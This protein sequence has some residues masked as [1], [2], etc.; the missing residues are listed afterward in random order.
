MVEPSSSPARA[1]L[2]AAGAEVFAD[3]GFG[4][5]STREICELAG[6]SVNMIHHY[7]GSKAGLLTAIIDQYGSEVLALPARLLASPPTSRDDLLSRMTLL[8]ETTLEACL[9]HRTLLK[10]VVREDASPDALRDYASAFTSFLEEG[11]RAGVV[12]QGLDA[13]MVTGA[14]LDRILNQVL[15]IPGIKSAHGTDISDP[16]YRQAWCAANVDFFLHGM[17]PSR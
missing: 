9:A 7:F 12:R 8:F 2:L 1:R 15:Y 3:R 4:G 17:L 10:V 13:E 14:V 5:G 16:Q 6:T 11:K